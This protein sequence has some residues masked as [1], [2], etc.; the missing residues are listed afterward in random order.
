MNYE[1]ILSVAV[2]IAHEAGAI[3]RDSFPFTALAHIGLKGAVNPVTETDIAAE[4]LIITRL[5]D[6][7]PD[8]RILAEESGGDEGVLK[9][10]QAP[11]PGSASSE[12][13]LWLIDPLDGTNNF[14][15]GFPHVGV[16]LALVE[17]GRPVVGVVHDP[18]RGETFAATAGGGAT[19]DGQPIHVSSVGHLAGA[20]LATGFPYDR[21]TADDN[22]VERLDHFL[23]RS[24]GVRRAGAAVLDL[25]YVACGRF[26]GFWEIRLKPWDVAAGVLLV[27]EAGGKAT[28]FEGTPGCISGEFIVASNGHIHAEM[29]RVIHEGAAAPRPE[30]R[31]PSPKRGGRPPSRERLPSS[32]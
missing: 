16:S 32:S 27:R 17:D 23:R 4:D 15:H 14:A 3:V 25:A 21:R 28:D 31:D 6:A 20:F 29:L 2:S 19:L 9:T 11:V 5:R 22:N 1:D 26:D 8:H 18:L 10:L 12:R 13:P 30:D 7:F 24:L